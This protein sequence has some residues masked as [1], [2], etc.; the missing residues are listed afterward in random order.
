MTKLRGKR[1]MAMMMV[2]VAMVI[3]SSFGVLITTCAVKMHSDVA[4]YV[5]NTEN[6]D[7]M[8]EYFLSKANSLTDFSNE[9]SVVAN[10]KS[11]FSSNAADNPFAEYDVNPAAN[12][13]G[14]FPVKRAQISA[15]CDGGSTAVMLNVYAADSVKL[16]VVARKSGTEKFTILVW[17]YDEV[18]TDIETVTL[19]S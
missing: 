16:Q 15:K 13:E 11:A 3:L 14:E 8:G 9:T 5:K 12:A 1:G 19:P 4:R 17:S 2:I 7:A 18:V 10:L 6:C